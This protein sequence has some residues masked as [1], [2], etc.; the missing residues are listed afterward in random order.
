MS[1]NA[2][3]NSAEKSLLL[4]LRNLEPLLLLWKERVYD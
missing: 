4:N 3:F 2:G 1:A